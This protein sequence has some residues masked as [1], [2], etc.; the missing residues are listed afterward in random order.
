M[1]ELLHDSGNVSIMAPVKE[2]EGMRFKLYLRHGNDA[3]LRTV[4]D[5]GVIFEDAH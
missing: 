3:E 1:K 2:D 5:F 4:T